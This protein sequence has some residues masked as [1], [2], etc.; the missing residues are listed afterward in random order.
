MYLHI[1]GHR[2]IEFPDEPTVS[3]IPTLL[4][5]DNPDGNK[6]PKVDDKDRPLDPCQHSFDAITKIRTEVFLFIGRVRVYFVVECLNIS[7]N[8]YLGVMP[9]QKPC[10]TPIITTTLTM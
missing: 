8:R 6:P 9:A 3:I 1:T 4:P 7:I 5:K 2:D 10:F